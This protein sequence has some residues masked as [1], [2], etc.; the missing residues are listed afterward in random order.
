MI[1]S[2]WATQ[3]VV[4][5]PSMLLLGMTQSPLARVVTSWPTASTLPTP[6]P[7]PTAGREAGRMG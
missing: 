1:F 4:Q 2:C 3:W 7:P 6:S 5:V